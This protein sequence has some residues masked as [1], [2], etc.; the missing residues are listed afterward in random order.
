MPSAGPS[1]ATQSNPGS[2]PAASQKS[3]VPAIDPASPP[4]MPD[5]DL[6]HITSALGPSEVQ[7]EI[8]A[9]V[10]AGGIPAEA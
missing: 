8:D 6:G 2:S 4:P 3:S 7:A 9:W 5:L 1:L 10:D